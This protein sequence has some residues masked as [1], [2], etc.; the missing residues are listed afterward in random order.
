MSRQLDVPSPFGPGRCLDP[1]TLES[2]FKRVGQG[3]KVFDQ[4]RIIHPEVMEIGDFSQIDEHVLIAMGGSMVLGRH[5]H[6]AT[7][8]SVT[9]GG[10]CFIGDFAGIS[11]G[12]RVITGTEEIEGGLSN[13]TVPADMRVVRRGRVRIGAHC[14]VFAG[15]I[16][17]PNVEMGEGAVVSAGSI[18]HHHLDPWCVYAGNPLVKIGARDKEPILLA[19]NELNRREQR[20]NKD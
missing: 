9:G 6:L 17:L 11:V 20:K 13:P 3:V 7:G 12:V 16:V 19:A 4:V 2:V 18:V 10:E 14:L 5:V 1:A 8:C 15:C